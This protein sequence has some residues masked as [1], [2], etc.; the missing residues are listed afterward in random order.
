MIVLEYILF[1]FYFIDR[2]KFY[3]AVTNIDNQTIPFRYFMV[4]LQ[5]YKLN[6]IMANRK[7]T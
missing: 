1:Y 4:E 5:I 7:P 6:T 3:L 2:T